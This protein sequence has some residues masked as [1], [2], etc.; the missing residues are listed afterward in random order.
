VVQYEGSHANMTPAQFVAEQ[1][2]ATTFNSG[3]PNMTQSATTGATTPCPFV[4]QTT[5][6]SGTT[7]AQPAPDGNL[8]MNYANTTNG[9]TDGTLPS[10]NFPAA[11]PE[12]PKNVTYT[13]SSGTHTI[14]VP[15][16]KVNPDEVAA[17][18]TNLVAASNPLNPSTLKGGSA[19]ALT[20]GTNFTNATLPASS[21]TA[22][23]GTVATSGGSVAPAAANI[24]GSYAGNL[25]ITGTQTNPIQIDGK[26]VVDGDVIIRGYVQ[27]QGQLYV[28]G[29]IYC[30]GDIIYNNDNVGT[31]NE[32]F[33]THTN[34]NGS[35][36]TNLVALV[37]GKNIVVGDYLSQVTQWA[38]GNADFYTTYTLNTTTHTVTPVT[39]SPEPGVK[40]S[41]VTGS[42]T[43]NYLNPNQIDIAPT[44]TLPSG[45]NLTQVP[46][47]TL[48]TSNTGTSWGGTNFA[49]FTVEQMAYFNRNELMK[50][51]PQLPTSDP[52][53]AT[54]YA[55]GAG[56]ANPNYDPTYVPK[57]YSMY[58][59]NSAAPATT[60][61]LAF[62]YSGSTYSPDPSPATTGHWNGTD[63]PHVYDY[64]TSVDA[65]P[66]GA[67]SA[68]AAANRNVINI[69]PAWVDPNTMMKIISSEQAAHVP[70]IADPQYGTAPNYQ[71]PDRRLD[72]VLYTNNAIFC[73]ERMQSNYYNPSTGLWSK[74]SAN[75]QGYMQVNG[76]LVAPDTG[77]LVTGNGSTNLSLNN[78]SNR[79]AFLIN[80]DPRVKNFMAVTNQN[81]TTKN[82]W[83]V[84]RQ[85]VVRT[86]MT[87]P[88]GP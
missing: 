54:S 4:N 69:H 2:D 31:L 83:G 47:A 60:P 42:S 1:L 88:P 19:V 27:G 55:T 85:G 9:Q 43:S 10:N 68:N 20:A 12:I 32:T 3:T 74:V 22:P 39:G 58:P 46:G 57:F 34:S 41:Y 65:L 56:A 70:V 80:Y 6:S 51:M 79:Q 15:D 33:G 17:V 35:Q 8:Y 73:V 40:Q 49:N 25:V 11:F 66:S 67:I 63:D 18:E 30:P 36:T 7:I 77:I 71:I 26:V 24:T 87:M 64:F 50:C 37:A 14:S 21:G 48:T 59:Y 82:L 61:P 29:N 5:N 86:R 72:G 16:N 13:D 52:T 62:L 84:T 81:F 53:K 76:A 44:V 75:S 78:S 38:S 45:T 23:T 28:T